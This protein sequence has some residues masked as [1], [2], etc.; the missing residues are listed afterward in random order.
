MVTMTSREMKAVDG[1]AEDMI[2]LSDN[3]VP[4]Y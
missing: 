4:F 1:L 3:A 2:V